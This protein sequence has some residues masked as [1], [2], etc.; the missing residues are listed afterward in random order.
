MMEKALWKV[1][2]SSEEEMELIRT[3]KCISWQL[4]SGSRS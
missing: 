4:V 2:C 3:E 1:T